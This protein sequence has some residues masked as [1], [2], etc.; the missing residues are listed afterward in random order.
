MRV[1]INGELDRIEKKYGVKI[2]YAG[3]SGS[4]AWGCASTTSE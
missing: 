1:T 4:R 3:K 2:I